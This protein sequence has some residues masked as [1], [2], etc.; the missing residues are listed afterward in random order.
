MVLSRKGIMLFV[1][2]AVKVWHLVL[3][4]SSAISQPSTKPNFLESMNHTNVS[5]LEKLLI[6]FLKTDDQLF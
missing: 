3:P 6:L 1:A 4:V 5:A 2:C